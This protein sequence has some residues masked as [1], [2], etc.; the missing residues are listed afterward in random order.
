MSTVA[1]RR[2]E[3]LVLGLSPVGIIFGIGAG[4]FIV[5]SVT[6][7]IAH[8]AAVLRRRQRLHRRRFSPGEHRQPCDGRRF[9]LQQAASL[10]ETSS[11]L[12]E[13]GSM[14]RLAPPSTP[15]APARWPARGARPPDHAV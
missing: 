13:M 4:H 5:R 11:V 7:L 14:I 12:V 3:T 6:V 2:N 10:E 1:Q 15:R 9:L 8:V